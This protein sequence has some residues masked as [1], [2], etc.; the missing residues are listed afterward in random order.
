MADSI[1]LTP[2]TLSSD[3]N[4]LFLLCAILGWKYFLEYIT[5]YLQEKKLSAR[6]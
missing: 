4:N 5:R 1:I 3:L 2:N 6:T